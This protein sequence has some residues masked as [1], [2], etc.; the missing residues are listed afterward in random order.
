MSGYEKLFFQKGLC[1]RCHC[2]TGG[3]Q[4]C[5]VEAEGMFPSFGKICPVIKLSEGIYEEASR[6]GCPNQAPSTPEVYLNWAL[7]PHPPPEV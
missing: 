5:V 2:E 3:W 1:S 7:R 4:A 6:V